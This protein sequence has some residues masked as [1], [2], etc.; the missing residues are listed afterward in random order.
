MACISAA[1]CRGVR[2]PSTA[3]ETTSETDILFRRNRGWRNEEGGIGIS[4]RVLSRAVQGS[5]KD[6]REALEKVADI[7]IL[8]EGISERGSDHDGLMSCKGRVE[9]KVVDVKSG[10]ILTA[11]SAYGAGVDVAERIAGKRALQAAAQ[12]LAPDLISVI[13]NKWGAKADK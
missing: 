3:H 6:D 2:P 13:V 1:E 11:Q 4:Q 9:L 8:G 12:N 5:L 10:E 7:L